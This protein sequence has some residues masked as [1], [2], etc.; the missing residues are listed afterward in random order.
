MNSKIHIRFPNEQDLQEN[1]VNELTNI[2]NCVYDEAESGMWQAGSQRINT[3][4]LKVLLTSK[5]LLLAEIKSKIV[6]CVNMGLIDE[7]IAEFGMLTADPNYRGLGI[8][9]ELVKSAE[10]W[11][12]ENGCSIMQLKLLTPREWKHP[13]KEFL[14]NW[15]T[16]IGYVFQRAT[17]FENSHPD[18]VD[19][20]ATLCD[21]STYHKPLN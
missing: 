19:Q 15:Y 7:E 16:R 4:V 11:A 6:G 21:F 5:T 8:G 3:D 2:I 10:K 17:A 18:K 9:R 20:L 14:K 12:I 13:S 1:N